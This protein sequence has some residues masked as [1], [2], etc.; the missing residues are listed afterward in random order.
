MSVSERIYEEVKKL[1]EPLQAEVLDFVQ[2]LA[3]RKKREISPE[4]ELVSAGLTLSLEMRGMET[5]DSPSY[6]T[7][8]L[9]EV[10]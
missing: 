10:F 8:D 9:S 3:S 2:H 5:E 6:S 7:E 1:P 4:S